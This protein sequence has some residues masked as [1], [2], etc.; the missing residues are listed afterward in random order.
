MVKTSPLVPF[1]GIKLKYGFCF[2]PKPSAKTNNDVDLLALIFSILRGWKTILFLALL[3]L[4]IGVLYSRYE[5][6]IFKSDAL[7]Q[8]ES[9]SGGI[10]ALGS[11][12][13]DLVASSNTGT[14]IF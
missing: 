12:I 2:T 11:N 4:L 10:S 8:I 9:S 5:T 3:G 13:S 1:N 6:T 7:I 14:I